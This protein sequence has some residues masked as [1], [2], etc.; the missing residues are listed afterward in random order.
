V[1]QRN[2]A[3]LITFIALDIAIVIGV[4]VWLTSGNRGAPEVPPAPTDPTAPTPG[5]EPTEPTGDD[6][7]ILGDW[8]Q[9]VERRFGEHGWLP[10]TDVP[11]LAANAAEELAPIVANFTRPTDRA[12]GH[13]ALIAEYDWRAIPLLVDAAA[14][15][16]DE[17]ETRAA[18]ALL[19]SVDALQT[20][21]AARAE[22]RFL[23]RVA[24][25][26][27]RRQVELAATVLPT[28]DPLEFLIATDRGKSHEALFRLDARVVDFVQALEELNFTPTS[29]Q[30]V[31][32]ETGDY[33]FYDGDSLTVQVRWVDAGGT[34]RE[35]RLESLMLAAGGTMPSTAWIYLG[36]ARGPD[37][38]L[39]AEQL[40]TVASLV[41]SPTAVLVDP[42]PLSQFE[43]VYTRSAL[44]PPA[45]T[46]V[47][48]VFRPE[49]ASIRAAR[50][51]E[52]SS[53]PTPYAGP[54]RVDADAMA[55]ML[56][57][58]FP[59]PD[60]AADAAEA[61]ATRGVAPGADPGKPG[62]APL[63]PPDPAVLAQIPEL[64]TKLGIE[65][66]RAAALEVLSGLDSRYENALESVWQR[67]IGRP[68]IRERLD[69]IMR[70]IVYKGVERD[71]RLYH[72]DCVFDREAETIVFDGHF[73]RY[74]NMPTELFIAGPR[75]PWH[76]TI[77]V[78]QARV[79]PMIDMLREMDLEFS[80]DAPTDRG[81]WFPYDGDTV[82]IEV[83]WR[84]SGDPNEPLA[85]TSLE[86]LRARDDVTIVRLEKTIVNSRTGEPLPLTGFKLVPSP[87]RRGLVAGDRI[88]TVVASLA[89]PGA[90]F[91]NPWPGA[92]VPY[93]YTPNRDVIPA[94]RTPARVFIRPQPPAERAVFDP[95]L[96]AAVDEEISNWPLVEFEARAAGWEADPQFPGV[97]AHPDGGSLGITTDANGAT[98]IT[99]GY[100]QFLRDQVQRN[101]EFGAIV[102]EK[103]MVWN[104]QP[105]WRM[106]WTTKAGS[107]GF[108]F[109]T[110]TK[111][112]AYTTYLV[113]EGETDA[114]KVKAHWHAV[115]DHLTMGREVNRLPLPDDGP[116]TQP[117]TQPHTDG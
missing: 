79:G 97:F 74:Q 49:A 105:A 6:S 16:I 43:G 94:P 91:Q 99:P 29:A 80:D 19:E 9:R 11:E 67:E 77:L 113:F 13:Q 54:E 48:L 89:Y 4:I 32:A 68:E 53:N 65:S 101:E 59:P 28:A 78:T 100:R 22:W 104:G 117:Q 75:G 39:A 27:R 8:R 114:A 57:R 31:P 25:T 103:E 52:L 111:L 73:V 2:A 61:G 96:Q 42:L 70:G 26:P 82:V 55:D 51:F 85:E 30:R 69:E 84:T 58:F 108:V 34:T 109:M 110:I 21:P 98:S 106:H 93:L 86:A 102:D 64:V 7:P 38:S 81:R 115:H 107:H 41:P 10:S 12:F 40:G 33:R 83:A 66:E 116:Q 44:M 14:R 87:E 62:F 17:G 60:D 24:W 76:E 45:G 112:Y 35:R 3:I 18:K 71:G 88:G 5:P 46:P 20:E 36:A 15:L 90:P 72:A 1:T 23:P 37:G 92:G 63:F 47:T 56:R 95:V 50:D